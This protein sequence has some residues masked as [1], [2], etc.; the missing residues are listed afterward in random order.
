MWALHE[1]KRDG[2]SVKRVGEEKKGKGKGYRKRT[3]RE[4][5]SVKTGV[6]CEVWIR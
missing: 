3:K 2:V 6:C 5:R 4:E 1:S